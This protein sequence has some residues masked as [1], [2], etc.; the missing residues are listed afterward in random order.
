MRTARTDRRLRDFGELSGLAAILALLCALLS[1]GSARAAR[2][3][4][5]CLE[6]PPACDH[7]AI[8]A[9]LDAA[10]EG[11]TVLVYPGAYS[12]RL[13]LRSGVTL[14]SRD[15]PQATVITATAGPIVS[16]AGA[17]AVTVQGFTVSGSETVTETTGF[18]LADSA[19]T[20]AGCVIRDLR[21]ADG[22][23]AA[24]DGASAT[25]IRVTGTGSLTVTDCIVE[26]VRGGHGLPG[27]EG[28][29]TGGD[30]AGIWAE[31]PVRITIAGGSVQQISG[32]A[33]GTYAY[34]PYDCAGRGGAAAGI[35][36]QSGVDLS[37]TGAEIAD[38]TGGAPCKAW[39]RYCVGGAGAAT[40]VWAAE[41]RV[42]LRDNTFQRLAI[43][44]SHGR[45]VAVAVYTTGCSEVRLEGNRISAVAAV[46]EPGDLSDAAG[47]DVETQEPAEAAPTPPVSGRGSPVRWFSDR[48]LAGESL[49]RG[50]Q[51]PA[52]PCCYPP[53][54][55]A[56]AVVSV[57][58][59]SLWAADN[60][61]AG[62]TG[63][64]GG[65]EAIGIGALDTRQAIVVRN[66]I[67]DI[68]G[69]APWTSAAGSWIEGA[70]EARVE[71]NVIG[72]IRGGSIPLFCY[73]D[74][75]DGGDAAGI[76]LRR[77]ADAAGQRLANNVV[78]SVTGGP[79]TTGT[80][81]APTKG[82]DAVAVS[83]AGGTAASLGTLDNFAAAA[84]FN[85]TLYGTAG[86]AGG[87]TKPSP[88]SDPGSPVETG[89]AGAAIGLRLLEG[90]GVLG[91]NN[92]LVG[93]GVAI[94]ITYGASVVLDYNAF[95]DNGANHPG[96]S[97]GPHDLHAPPRFVD[98]S[99]GNVHLG[100]GS[101]LIDAGTNAGAPL[102]D[103]EGDLRPLDGNRDGIGTA[104]IGADEYR[105][106]AERRRYLPMLVR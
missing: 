57:A 89:P 1:A 41:S 80:W 76:V 44:A 87:T 26:N 7:T 53:A 60:A 28:G 56:A 4:T 55:R 49:L 32:G 18:D 77:T 101:P 52:S 12:G 64:G 103:F 95:W 71:A 83:V 47:V 48:L 38:V 37:V 66:R 23:T 74:G 97:A 15:G 21:G 94:S 2:V 88:W 70:E 25:G 27:I 34:W 36:A 22:S 62:I 14:T 39:A 30:A 68:A 45:A 10:A 81:F 29:A 50:E 86:G 82:G 69:G 84:F 90:A 35:S 75:A 67:T 100:F 42:L 11:D 85:N 92:A 16:A 51:T 93:H 6:G 65:G 33:A 54:G 102:E 43:Q 40:A 106:G 78:W 8:Q 17:V 9:G 46:E 20:L 19:V 99:A 79:G 58:D 61:I 104:D 31:G 59:R 91:F 73:E 72:L 105:P 96:V 98:L 3:I 63:W 5:V 24:L 13:A